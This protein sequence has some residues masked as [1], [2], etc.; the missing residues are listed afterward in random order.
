MIARVKKEDFYG[1]EIFQIFFFSLVF[2]L[3]LIFFNCKMKLLCILT[4]NYRDTFGRS[5]LLL[6]HFWANE[7]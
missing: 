1:R 4:S 6:P 2:F 7:C 3:S 5:Q